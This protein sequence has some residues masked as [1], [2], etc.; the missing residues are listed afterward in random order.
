MKKPHR[1]TKKMVMYVPDDFDAMVLEA[2]ER[3]W[4]AKSDYIRMAITERLERDG[5]LAETR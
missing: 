1:F 5:A 3:K 2:S 4:M